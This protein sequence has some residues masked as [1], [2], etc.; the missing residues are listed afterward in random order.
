MMRRWAEHNGCDAE[1][2]EE[3]VSS[4]VCKRTW[5]GCDATVLAIVDGVGHAWPGKRQPAFEATFGPGT[6]EIGASALI[7]E[8]LF[9]PQG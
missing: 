5:Q 3:D 4:N 1:P 7:F 2:V 9:D 8:L 6:T